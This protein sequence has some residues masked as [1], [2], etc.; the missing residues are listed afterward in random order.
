MDLLLSLR[1]EGGGAHVYRFA[2]PEVRIGRARD[3]GLRLPDPRISG[4]HLRLVLRGT[5]WLAVDPGH[6]AGTTL[7]GARLEEARPLAEGDRLELLGHSLE[8]GFDEGGGLTTDSRDT[9]RLAQALLA[10]MRV[11]AEPPRRG[12]PALLALAALAFLGAALLLLL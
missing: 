2:G 7:N 12:T 5:Q 8:I 11:E 10:E 4:L 9:E 6:T 3:C 1:R